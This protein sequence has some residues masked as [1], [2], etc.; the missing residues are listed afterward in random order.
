[1]MRAARPT[2]AFWRESVTLATL[3]LLL[4]TGAAPVPTAPAPPPPDIVV[5]AK[6]DQVLRDFV[7]SMTDPD[8]SRQLTRWDAEICPTV[9]GIDPAQAAAMQAR[10][11][12]IAI[13]L[14]LNARAKGCMTTMIVIVDNHPAEVATSLSKQFPITLRT[15]GRDKLL[16]FVGTKRPVRWISV[17]DPCGFGGCSLP[18][19]RLRSSERPAFQAMI[20]IVDGQQIN[21]FGLD[22]LSD[23]VSLVALA[24]PPSDRHWP[25]TSI[26][27]MFDRERP[28]SARFQV[29]GDDRAFLEGLYKTPTDGLGQAQ[30]T[31]IVQNMKKAPQ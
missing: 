27:S 21:G 28:P 16:R 8:R 22:E 6:P 4:L 20:I 3:S 12:E 10:I 11:A 15:D 5:Q 14:H 2:P 7:R 9:V 31:S 25:A 1:M 18:N 30:R 17:T 19:S 26:L 23:Y 24:N 29:T 13:S